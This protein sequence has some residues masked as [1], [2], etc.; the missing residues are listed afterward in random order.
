M[1]PNKENLLK[2]ADYLLS[3][4]VDYSHFHM[5]YFCSSDE[6]FDCDEAAHA[7]TNCGTVGCALG[8][9][10]AAGI[11][12]STLGW[13][14]YCDKEFGIGTAST[15]WDWCFGYKWVRHDNTPQG[16][17]KRIKYFLDFGVPEGYRSGL[18]DDYRHTYQDLYGEK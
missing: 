15:E 7:I 17:G 11:A 8:H 5:N 12:P 13:H 14:R 9:G 10:P 16:A 6:S 1:E 4:P 3:L 18:E 2:L